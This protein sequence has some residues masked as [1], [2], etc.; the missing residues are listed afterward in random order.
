MSCCELTGA[1]VSGTKDACEMIGLIERNTEPRSR[2]GTD[3]DV[4][5]V[6]YI[7]SV[8]YQDAARIFESSLQDEVF[9]G[10]E[11]LWKVVNRLGCLPVLFPRQEKLRIGPEAIPV[12]DVIDGE[13]LYLQLSCGHLTGVGRANRRPPHGTNCYNLCE[14]ASHIIW[15]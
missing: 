8:S 12:Q 1:G 15:R 4:F 5:P 11:G 7:V 3:R 10:V 2:N 6:A 14:P 13:V 9:R